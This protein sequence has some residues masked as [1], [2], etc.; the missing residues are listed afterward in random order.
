MGRKYII[1]LDNDLTVQADTF[2]NLISFMENN[3]A[4]GIC[5]AKLMPNGK[6]KM[7][8][9]MGYDPNNFRE[10]IGYL[11][12]FLLKIFPNSK[13]LKEMSMFFILNYWDYNQV[14]LVDWVAEGGFIIR[15]SIF[16]QLNGF[17]ERFFMFFEGP[18]LCKRVRK[19]GYKVYFNPS[20]KINLFDGHTHNDQ[21]R[22]V[23]FNQNINFTKNIIFT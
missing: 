18:D 19:I 20:A 2:E 16:E 6:G 12:G 9:N 14:I 1:F 10:S 8:W 7:W 23:W 21:K 13:I 3:S 11:F 22:S 4:A 15:K 5:G 17:D